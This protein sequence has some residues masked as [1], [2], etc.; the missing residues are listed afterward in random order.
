MRGASRFFE[1]LQ[2][3]KRDN[4]GR[5][6]IDTEK[7]V[8]T[9]RRPYMIVNYDNINIFFGGIFQAG[10]FYDIKKFKF[11]C[12]QEHEGL[13]FIQIF[14]LEFDRNGTLKPFSK[15]DKF[16]YDIGYMEPKKVIREKFDYIK[17]KIATGKPILF[18]KQTKEGEDRPNVSGFNI[19]LPDGIEIIFV[20]GGTKPPFYFLSW[21]HLPHGSSRRVTYFEDV[22]AEDTSLLKCNVCTSIATKHCSHCRIATYCSEKCWAVDDHQFKCIK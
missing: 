9:N 10:G 13:H 4:E 16:G 2:G 3:N 6:T 12:A 21:M 11:Y 5:P 19:P 22:S 14:S 17:R 8:F 1:T 18:L 20:E 7:P 15:K